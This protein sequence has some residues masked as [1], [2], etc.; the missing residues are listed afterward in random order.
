MGFS[1]PK[2]DTKSFGQEILN[3][4]VQYT[5]DTEDRLM[6][7]LDSLFCKRQADRSFYFRTTN[8]IYK[9]SDGALSELCA[10]TSSR[11]YFKNNSEFLNNSTTLT[12]GDLDRWLEFA[13]F[14]IAADEQDI[15]SLPKIKKRLDEL[16]VNCKCDASE[17]ALLKKYNA[18][19]YKKIEF[20]LKDP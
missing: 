10:G 8:K 9:L 15:K 2:F 13:A 4:Q 17:Q 11:Y 20:N 6:K 12:S 19:L 7:M 1:Q 14:D 18:T 3:G 5:N 16:V